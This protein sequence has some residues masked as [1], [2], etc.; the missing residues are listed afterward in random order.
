MRKSICLFSFVFLLAYA[1]AGA[2]AAGTFAAIYRAGADDIPPATAPDPST[3]EGG[4]WVAGLPAADVENFQSAGVSPDG[5]SGFNAWRMLDNSTAGGQFL[6][7]NRALTPEQHAGAANNGWRLAAHLRVADPVAG[8][9]GAN[10]TVLIYGNN[11]GRRWIAFFDL[12]PTN[13]LVVTLAGGPTLL[14]TTDTNLATGYN[15][16]EFV[17]DPAT[18]R[19]TYLFNGAALTTSYAGTTGTYDGVQWG[20][21]SSGGRGDAYWNRVSFEIAD[22][23]PPPEVLAHPQSSTNAVGESVTFEAA[24]ANTVTSFQWFKDGEP[25]VGATTSRYTI[26]F[27]TTADAG[28]YVCRAANAAGVAETIPATLTVQTDILAPTVT[29]ISVSVVGSRVRIHYSEPVE[30][31]SAVDL[32]SYAFQDNTLEFAG[33]IVLVDPFTV[34]IPVT[35]APEPGASHVLLISFVRDLA[36]NEIGL[37]T[38]FP[39]TGPTG[40]PLMHQL[41]AAFDGSSAVPHEVDGVTW[42][43][44][45]GNENDALAV[46]AEANRRPVLV[47]DGPGGHSVLRFVQAEQH[48]LRISGTNAAGLEGD[49]FTWFVVSKPTT[50]ANFPNVIRHQ[51]TF[52]AANWGSFYFAGNAA[53]TGDQP[54]LVSNGRRGT[55]GAVEAFAFPV[56][57]NQWHLVTGSVNG[58]AG[59]SFS[60]VE[61]LADG[62]SVSGV[63]NV[64]EALAFGSAVGTWIGGTAGNAAH[65][66]DGDMAEVLLYRGALDPAQRSEVEAYL[67]EKYLPRPAV[68]ITRDAGAI[69]IEFSGILQSAEDVGGAFEDVP[70]NPVGLLVIPAGSELSR[71]FFRARR[72]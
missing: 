6:T 61:H 18:T 53:L 30:P 1:F 3:A 47:S 13:T 7:W 38:P 69:T 68:S 62:T 10:S 32:F 72:P 41:V 46:S 66:F 37:D 19:A 67:R 4:S 34:D 29:S 64:G 54:A 15:L 42:R 51:S 60:R 55:G 16:H 11:A 5:A 21:G 40:F 2:A 8:N 43:D 22:P 27:V 14:V 44:R 65:N 36:G 20:T 26:A 48:R 58:P 35:P 33:A 71:Q 23:P 57:S 50:F 49:S 9:A 45:S 39:F 12:T 31:G 24:F 52:S 56:A 28:D 63:N 59:E 25:I 70:G 17:F